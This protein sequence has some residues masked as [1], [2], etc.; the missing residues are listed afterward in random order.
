MAGMQE[1]E[2]TVGEDELSGDPSAPTARLGPRKNFGAGRTGLEGQ[3]RTP[4]GLR[5]K[6]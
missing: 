4:G 2:Y 5:A 3:F 6:M 1:I